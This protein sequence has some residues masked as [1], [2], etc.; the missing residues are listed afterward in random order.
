VSFDVVV[1]AD[2]DWGIGKANGLPWP[3]LSGDLQ[4]FKRV[5]CAAPEGQRN[6]IVMGRKTW[7]S[8]EVAGKP[9]PRRLNIVIT[10][11]ALEVP[12]DAV[13]ARSLDEA[14]AV[15]GVA[16]VFVVGGAA[17]FSQAFVHPALRWVYLTRIVGRF[18]CEVRI[19]D[20]DA[21]GF[22]KDSW[23]GEQELDESG[24]RYRIER[25]KPRRAA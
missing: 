20:L 5:T 23:E 10:R 6:A 3:K 11:Q 9:L 22:T 4:H 21:L 19:A 18:G 12:A 15:G 16:G 2:L 13:V 17:I 7:E 25:L 24:V 8:R 14:L 1:A